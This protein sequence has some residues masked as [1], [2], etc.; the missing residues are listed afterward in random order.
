M[1]ATEQLQNDHEAIT[2]ALSIL[3]QLALRLSSG[4]EVDAAHFEQVLEFIQVFA[5]KCHHG[6]EEHFLFP[7]ME[8]A[9]IPRHGGPVGVMLSEHDH[10]RA[11]I[12]QLAASWHK[13]KSGDRAVAAELAGSAH[14]YVALLNSH[15]FK[16]N[17]ILFP[18][19]EAH[20]SADTQRQLLEQFDRLE[21]E[22]IGAVKR[23][24]FDRSLDLLR[25]TYLSR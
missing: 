15:I 20:L 18:M 19:A 5:D 8:A 9:G 7:A 6:K 11:L 2:L 12:Q 1:T 13:Y 3:E 16:E 14:S 21:V 10:G 22:R 23:E 24:Q 4:Q 25:R 17:N